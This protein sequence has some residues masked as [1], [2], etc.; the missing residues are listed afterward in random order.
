VDPASQTALGAKCLICGYCLDALDPA[1]NCPECNFSIGRSLR[2]D[3]LLDSPGAHIACLRVGAHLILWGTLTF[4]AAGVTF[5]AWV[6]LTNKLNEIVGW[7]VVGAIIAACVI[8]FSGWFLFTSRDRGGFTPGI[9]TMRRATRVGVVVTA[10]GLTVIGGCLWFSYLA[11]D[12]VFDRG[13][14]LSYMFGAVMAATPLL[15]LATMIVS[16]LYLRRWSRRIP[17]DFIFRRA[18]FMMWAWPALPVLQAVLLGGGQFLLAWVL[19]PG[20]SNLYAIAFVLF[21]AS[22]LTFIIL[23]AHL[24]F[25]TVRALSAVRRAQRAAAAA[26]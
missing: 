3:L 6:W 23:Y 12:F 7:N 22:V 15:A 13:D 10:A 11:G 25:R 17:D 20:P 19:G 24:I 8:F 16:M 21:F 1:G 4:T 26:A 9:Q 5:F 2:G 14:L 18:R